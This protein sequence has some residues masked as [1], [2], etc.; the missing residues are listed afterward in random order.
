ISFCKDQ[1][2][3][4]THYFD[5]KARQ[6]L[7][8]EPKLMLL[9]PDFKD[10]DKAFARL[11]LRLKSMP[12]ANFKTKK[13]QERYENAQAELAQ[14]WKNAFA[15]LAKVVDYESPNLRLI[16]L[17][18]KY[19]QTKRMEEFYEKLLK[20]KP[21]AAVYTLLGLIKKDRSGMIIFLSKRFF[22]KRKE[23]K[24]P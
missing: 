23:R 10:F 1:Y 4:S 12:S 20:S 19:E 7:S 21:G 11:E 9:E 16:E 24:R 2:A 13:E 8:I 3:T 17:G 14:A 18:K 5:V 15:E 6:N 22:Q